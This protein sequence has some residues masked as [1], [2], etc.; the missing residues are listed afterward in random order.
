MSNSS[1]ERRLFSGYQEN[2]NA[3][4]KISLAAASVLAI[5]AVTGSAN[6][7]DYRPYDSGYAAP[8]P[9]YS[10]SGY[11]RGYSNAGYASNSTADIDARERAQQAEIARA[12]RSGQLSARELRVLEAEQAH[13][14]A[15][16]R[17][18][19]ADG[20]VSPA[21]RAQIKA[22]QDRAAADI[23]QAETNRENAYNTRPVYRNWW[24]WY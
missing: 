22:A 9:V 14:R 3:M 2:E 19:K 16:E 23:R 21:E 11:N 1:D 10:N 7:A 18:A 13:I 17:N 15:L 6:A 8:A 5:V 24:R 4:T 12:N 20:Y